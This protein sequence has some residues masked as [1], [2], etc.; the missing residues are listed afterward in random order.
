M[1]SDEDRVD[2]LLRRLPPDQARAVRARV[3]DEQEYAQIARQVQTS[4]SVIRPRVSRGLATLR[5]IVK[6]RE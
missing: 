5:A 4:E 3:I 2:A 1:E 6:E